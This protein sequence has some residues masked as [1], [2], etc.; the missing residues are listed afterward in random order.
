MKVTIYTASYGDCVTKEKYGIEHALG[1][2]LLARGLEE[3]YH[4]S[5]TPD[6]IS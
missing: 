1:L 6:Q 3:L 4:L 5:Y 2:K